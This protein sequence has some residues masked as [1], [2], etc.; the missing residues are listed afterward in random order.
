MIKNKIELITKYRNIINAPEIELNLSNLWNFLPHDKCVLFVDNAQNIHIKTGVDSKILIVAHL[1]R[2]LHKKPRLFEYADEP[3]VLY[4][5]YG[6]DDRAGVISALELLHK[7][8]GTVDVLFTTGEESGCIGAKEIQPADVAQY[9]LIFELD[10]HGNSDFINECSHGTLCNTDFADRICKYIN[11]K[12]YP[13]KPCKGVY[14]DVGVLR[15]KNKTAQ[16]FY[17]SCGYYNEH[18]E[19]EC[20]RVDEFCN[21]IRKADLI[22]EYVQ[23]NPDILHPFEPEVQT[24]QT[25]RTPYK[26]QGTQSM[27]DDYTKYNDDVGYYCEECGEG[28]YESDML[29]LNQCPYCGSKKVVIE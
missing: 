5:A 11:G 4:G 23:K 2:V 1:D 16:I 15:Q 12:H 20:L 21:A 17:M 25:P 9:N 18:T 13:L 19:N 22:I 26:W 8:C 27:F 14:T 10:R 6:W 7:W 3:N 24:I 29:G 28:F